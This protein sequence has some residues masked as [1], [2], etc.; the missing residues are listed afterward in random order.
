MNNRIQKNNV[1]LKKTECY[2][3]LGENNLAFETIDRIP[4]FGLTDSIRFE[5]L[6]QKALCAYLSEQF[7]LAN[8]YLIQI[9]SI[10]L[11]KIKNNFLKVNFLQILVFNEQRN[12]TASKEIL[13]SIKDSLN[14]IEH[15]DILVSN[16]SKKNIPKMRNKETQFWISFL[17]GAGIAYAGKP[18]EG[19]FNFTINAAALAFGVYQVYY[20]YYL[21]GYFGSTFLL[22]KFYMGGRKRGEFLL[23]KRNYLKAKDFNEK[24]KNELVELSRN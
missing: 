2:K 18:I 22:Q 13:I 8:S 5:I 14:N 19:I 9:Q 6:F 11:V 1:L 20:K 15:Y 10:S 21:T 17:P 12:W 7:T 3:Q 24:I 16:Y 23:E 4:L